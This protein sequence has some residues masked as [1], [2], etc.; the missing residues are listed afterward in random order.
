MVISP[1]REYQ[2]IKT[3]NVYIVLYIA[4]HSETKELLVI[5]QRRD[6][7]P[8]DEEEIWARPLELFSHKFLAI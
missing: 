6:R 1:G 8:I 7:D 3:G 2:N 5:Y 4:T